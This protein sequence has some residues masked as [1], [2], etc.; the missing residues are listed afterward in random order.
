MLKLRWS[1]ASPFARKVRVAAQF[2]GHT[3]RIELVTADTL[4]PEDPLRRD[5]PLGKI[6]C[7]ILDDGTTLYDS[8]VIVEFLDHEAGGGKVLPADWKGR[9]AALKL[10]ALAD[11]ILDAALLQLY[12]GRFRQ[13]EKHE[14]GWIT[15]QAGKV[16]RGLAMLEAKPPAITDTPDIGTITVACMLEWIEFRFP[17]RTGTNYPALMAFLAAFN[18]RFPGFGKTAPNV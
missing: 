4:N 1:P 8:R 14:P 11:G 2:T 15:Y 18:A 13:P 9:L 7:L 3:D 16:E 6:P 17:G 12:E 10:Q 5:N